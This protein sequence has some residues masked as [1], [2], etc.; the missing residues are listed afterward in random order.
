MVKV[1]VQL[2]ALLALCLAGERPAEGRAMWVLSGPRSAPPTSGN[3][4]FKSGKPNEKSFAPQTMGSRYLPSPFGNMAPKP[5]GPKVNN[6]AGRKMPPMKPLTDICE[7]LPDKCPVFPPEAPTICASDGKEYPSTCDLLK[8]NCDSEDDVYRVPCK[9]EAPFF[10][11]SVTLFGGKKP[12]TNGGP[13]PVSGGSPGFAPSVVTGFRPSVEIECGSLPECPLAKEGTPKLCASDGKT[14]TSQCELEKANCAS[15]TKIWPVRCAGTA[16]SGGFGQPGPFPPPRWPASND[17]CETLPEVCPDV[18]DGLPEI[19]GSDGNTY[20][21]PCELEKANCASDTKIW[22]VRCEGDDE[23]FPPGLLPPPLRPP[24][25]DICDMLPKVCPEALDGLPE[26]CGSDGKTYSS[27][28]E[29][30]K[31]NCASDTRIWPVRCEGDDETF[32]PGLFPPPPRPPVEDICDMLPEVCPEARD[33]LPELCGSDGKTYSSPCE[34]QKANCASD[35]KIRPVRCEGDDDAFPPGLLPPPLRPPMEDICDMLPEV[36]PEAPD[37]LPELCGSDGK[38]YSSPCEFQKAGC[39]SD[40]KIFLVPCEGSDPFKGRPPPPYP[41]DGFK[42]PFSEELCATLPESCPLAPEGAPEVCGSDGNKYE[43]RCD[44]MKAVCAS[45]GDIYPVPCDTDLPI[46][47]PRPRPR[48]M[49]R[50]MPRPF[51]LNGPPSVPGGDGPAI[52][53]LPEDKSPNAASRVTGG[54]IAPFGRIGQKSTLAGGPTGRFGFLPSAVQTLQNRPRGPAY[55]L[56]SSGSQS[57][58]QFPAGIFPSSAGGKYGLPKS[59][60]GYGAGGNSAPKPQPRFGVPPGMGSK[61]IP[62]FGG[63]LGRMSALAKYGK[64][65]VYGSP[66]AYESD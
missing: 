59:M 25:E 14:Y 46:L 56:A 41:G 15:D 66:S 30:Q 28:C 54:I 60:Q 45:E 19:C 40:V 12:F 32:P 24:M 2:A 61:G 36:C 18:P 43:S 39:G 65:N 47:Q 57:S 49:L 31:A 10:K 21:S 55:G 6:G 29:L 37:R 38:T 27:P 1:Q 20:S 58:R 5:F 33:G 50:P 52:E 13:P 64:P 3:N 44:L 35:I 7:T 9:D 11:P 62:L 4:G 26:L 8:A 42:P 34:M 23:T 22:P 48:P 51:F 53:I 17:R 16:Q 63:P